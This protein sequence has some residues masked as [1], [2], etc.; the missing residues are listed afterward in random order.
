M[1]T[2]LFSDI[3]VGPIRSRRLGSSLGVN[4]LP[5]NRKICSFDCTYCECGYNP[6]TKAP[7][8]IF[9][10]LHEV[11][12]RLEIKLKEDDTQ[13]TPFT[14]QEKYKYMADKNPLL[15]NLVQEFKLSLD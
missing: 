15:K 12:K 1:S 6:D 8:V 14:I 4:L 5:T 11:S 2:F 9:P 13:Q 3:I 7:K 10:E